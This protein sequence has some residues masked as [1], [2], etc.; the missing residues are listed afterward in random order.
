MRGH[1]WAKFISWPGVTV[2]CLFNRKHPAAEVYHKQ[3][4]TGLTVVFKYRH[5]YKWPI[6]PKPVDTL[7]KMFC[8]NRL[9]QYSIEYNPSR[10]VFGNRGSIVVDNSNTNNIQKKIW[11]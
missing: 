9:S 7:S 11:V 1:P 10:N 8:K 6:N 4:G 2:L 5:C 3:N